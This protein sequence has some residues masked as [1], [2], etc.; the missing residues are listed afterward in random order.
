MEKISAFTEVENLKS[1]K[2][3]VNSDKSCCDSNTTITFQGENNI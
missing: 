1:N 3:L 2:V